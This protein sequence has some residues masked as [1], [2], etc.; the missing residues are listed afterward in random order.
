MNDSWLSFQ[1]QSVTALRPVVL[2]FCLRRSPVDEDQ[3]ATTKPSCRMIS[4]HTCTQLIMITSLRER[5]KALW[6]ACLHVCLSVC[7]SVCLYVCLLTYL[8]NHLSR[9]HDIFCM[10]PVAVA[11]SCFDDS[12]LCMVLWMVSCFHMHIG[13]SCY[14][15]GAVWLIPTC[16]KRKVML[17]HN[18]PN[19]DA[20]RWQIIYCD[21]PG[22]T[23]ELYT[24]SKVCY[25]QFHVWLCSAYMSTWST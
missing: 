17:S 7:L 22:C 18:G 10:L 19:T 15:L 1:P 9:L 3:C 4:Y 20:G 2:I 5:C 14:G 23:A 25:H 13:Q 11:Q 16:P 8:K 12:A 24:W 21:C 6:S